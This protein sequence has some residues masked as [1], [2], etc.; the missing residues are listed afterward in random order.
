MSQEPCAIDLPDT[1]VTHDINYVANVG[2][3]TYVFA[4]YEGLMCE[5]LNFFVAD[6][7]H[8][9]AREKALTS[10]LIREKLLIVLQDEHTQYICVT[11]EQL[12]EV[13]DAF[14]DL[15]DRRNGLIHGRPATAPDGKSP[16]LNYQAFKSGKYLDFMWSLEEVQ[17]FTRDV[18]EAQYVV[19]AIRMGLQNGTPAPARRLESF[20]NKPSLNEKVRKTEATDQP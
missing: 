20:P 10:G 4:G 13:H 16:V 6:F 18:S 5:V 3:A 14:F 8:Y 7:R 15:I 17:R 1:R 11:K 2:L 12:E 9:V 19:D